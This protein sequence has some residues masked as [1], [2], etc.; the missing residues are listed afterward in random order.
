VLVARAAVARDVLPEGL[1]AKGWHVDVVEAYRTDPVPID[2][3]TAAAIAEAEVVTFTSS[4]TVT[5]FLDALAGAP[6]P[7]ATPPVVAAIGPVT[8]A[9][10]RDAGLEVSVEAPVH[11]IAGLVD[12]VV[13][14]A[15]DRPAR[16]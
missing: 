7:I 3:A 4:S 5:N 9:T 1:R 14:W 2:A 16:R 11:T 13:A 15:A 8:A 12:A 6:T 10:A